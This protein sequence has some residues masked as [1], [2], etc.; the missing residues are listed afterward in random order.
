MAVGLTV[1]SVA[2][3]VCGLSVAS[4]FR[5]M[6]PAARRGYDRYELAA[7]F[8]ACAS[9]A[10]ALAVVLSVLTVAV[11]APGIDPRLGSRGY[12]LAVAAYAAS[13][14]L[15]NLVPEAWYAAG[16][17]RRGSRALVTLSAGGAVG[18][19]AA[20]WLG[21]RS[22][23]LML[24]GPGLGVAALAAW[25]VRALQAAGLVVLGREDQM[26]RRAMLR[27]SS[28]RVPSLFMHI[29]CGRIDRYI[30]AF[31]ADPAILG[32]YALA[33]AIAE[34]TRLVGTAIGQVLFRN[35]AV[36]VDGDGDF[37]RLLVLGLVGTASVA[38]L[39]SIAGLALIVPVFGQDFAVARP[40]LVILAVGEVCFAP[41]LV[42]YRALLA[43]WARSAALIG[44]AGA[45]LA[46]NL[47]W[48]GC[49]RW[50]G[51]GAAV[52][53]AATYAAMSAM[54]WAS[55]ARHLRQR[56]ARPMEQNGVRPWPV[57]A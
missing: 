14:A 30:L 56:P 50:Q 15:T 57:P 17:F 28:A 33:T 18:L 13:V 37:P 19:A 32:A 24:G 8:T 23:V 27:S 53:S 11:S 12:L 29:L 7:S 49:L 52:A 22:P 54:A 9:G 31:F 1:G 44:L 10:V 21:P 3:M 41:Y 36:R 16:D 51:E 34:A 38:A 45:V 55:L 25:E 46:I 39:L 2:G 48:Y 43:N 40:M 6:R 5:S 35:L 42:S 4:A 26:V 47:Y 20:C